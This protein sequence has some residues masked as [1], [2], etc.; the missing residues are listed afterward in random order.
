MLFIA[1][2]SSD[3]EETGERIKRKYITVRR[4][5]KLLK[6]RYEEIHKMTS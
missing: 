5:E 4:V 2:E 1:T 3:L 6:K